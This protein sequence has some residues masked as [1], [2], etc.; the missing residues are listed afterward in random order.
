MVW[1]AEPLPSVAARLKDWGLASI[2]FEPCA[3]TP[4]ERHLLS[5]MGS[6]V[7]RLENVGATSAGGGD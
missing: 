1:E 7:D 6:N 4:E 3:R 5:V 2:V